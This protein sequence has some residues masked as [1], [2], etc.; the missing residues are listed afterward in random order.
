MLEIDKIF[1][2]RGFDFA[3]LSAFGFEEKNG[4]YCYTCPLAV[5]G[6]AAAVRV[7]TDS[8]VEADVIDTETGDIYALVKS[9]AATGAFV[10]KIRAELVE[11]LQ[12]IADECTFAEVFQTPFAKEIIRYAKEKY[13]NDFEFLWPKFPKNAIVRRQDNQKWYAAVLT[14]AAD[15]I[16]REGKD[17]IEIIDL[18]CPSEELEKL[19]DSKKYFPGWHMNKKH[20]LTICLDGSVPLT[21]ILERMDVSYALAK[22]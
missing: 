1:F 17:I 3:K 19:V 10:G 22:K 11:I 5:G 9:P 12:K 14:A 8:R 4:V 16:G 18:R 20:W 7:N 21:E 2:C 13:R 6:F 15:K